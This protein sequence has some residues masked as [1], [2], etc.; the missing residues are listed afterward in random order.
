MNNLKLFFLA[1]TITQAY[2]TGPTP[3]TNLQFLTGSTVGSEV[4]NLASPGQL[5]GGNTT[6]LYNTMNDA[7]GLKLITDNG[8]KKEF[9]LSGLSTSGLL[10]TTSIS[11]SPSSASGRVRLDHGFSGTVSSNNPG[12]VNSNTFT[13]LFTDNLEITDASFNLSSMNTAGVTWEYTVIQLLNSNGIPFSTL[14]NPGWTLGANSQYFVGPATGFSGPAGIGNYIA[15]SKLTVTGVGLNNT[16]SGTSGPNDNFASFN[17]STVGLPSGT[18][19]GGI[20][21]ITYLEDVRGINNGSSNLT[22]SLL[23][24]NISG[25]ICPVVVV[26]VPTLGQWGLIILFL[27]LNSI[28]AIKIMQRTRLSKSIQTF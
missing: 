13:L 12:R 9:K 21:I 7:N 1:F 14:T 18:I 6:F 4:L 2:A 11:L 10:G 28:G 23:D 17:Y 15:A 22:T 24:F 8:D 26:V 16:I 20:R 25:I 27:L 19:I 3:F 5:L